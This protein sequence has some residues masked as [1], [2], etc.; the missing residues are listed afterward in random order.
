MEYINTYGSKPKQKEA[1]ICES[2]VFMNDFFLLIARWVCCDEFLI[3]QSSCHP[4]RVVF[5]NVSR[6]VSENSPMGQNIPQAHYIKFKMHTRET[7][8]V[9]SLMTVSLGTSDITDVPRK[10]REGTNS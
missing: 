5:L 2:G 9:D 3:F 8:P 10:N 7:F 1:K 6:E 4:A